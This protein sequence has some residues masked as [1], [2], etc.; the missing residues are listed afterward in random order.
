MSHCTLPTNFL[1][2]RIDF[3]N[4]STF[5]GFDLFKSQIFTAI[6]VLKILKFLTNLI[7]KLQGQNSVR[8]TAKPSSN[9]HIAVSV[10]V[11]KL[12]KSQLKIT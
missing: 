1:F 3:K 10:N 5:S 6:T 7:I 4:L 9:Y 8:L 12:E 2:L 11:K